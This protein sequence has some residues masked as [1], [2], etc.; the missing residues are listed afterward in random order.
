MKDTNFFDWWETFTELVH[1][2]NLE[3]SESKNKIREYWENKDVC[4]EEAIYKFTR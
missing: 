4:I 3:I 1:N 2:N